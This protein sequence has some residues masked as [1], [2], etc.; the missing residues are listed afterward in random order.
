MEQLNEPDTD[1]G[2]PRHTPPPH[3]HLSDDAAGALAWPV[4][5]PWWALGVVAILSVA[6]VWA[7]LRLR[8]DA[9]LEGLF[10]RDSASGKAV[11]RVLNDFAVAEELLL[12]VSL[13]DGP[14]VSGS[15][16]PAP[17]T[18][19]ALLAFA[20]RLEDSMRTDPD[21][22]GMAADVV[23]RADPQTQQY[24]ERVVA[25]AGLFYLDD[26]AFEQARARLTPEAMREQLKRNE[27][28]VS[29]PGPAAGAMAKVLLQDPLR[30]HEFLTDRFRGARALAPGGAAGA[31]GGPP[32][33]FISPD[34]RSLLIRI[35]GARPPSDMDFTK[36]FTARVAR[37]VDAVNS[38]RLDV[39]Y[40]GA[41]AIAAASERAIRSDAISSSTTSFLYL[42]ALFCL[43]YRSPLRLFALA[44][45]PVV[46]GI[47]VGAG[48][49][50]AWSSS[51]TPMTAV[52]GAMLAE[53][54]IN[55]SV[56]YLSLY[57]SHRGAG[58]A[59]RAAASGS[60]REIAMPLLAAWC[61]SIVGFV[62]VGLSSLRVLRD[63]AVLGT[64]T[65][66]GAVVMTLLLLPA[67]LVLLDR[68]A[69]GPAGAD[70]SAAPLTRFRFGF[71]PAL[72]VMARG[73]RWLALGFG[74]CFL[75]SA[76]VVALPGDRLPLETD[77]TVM[78]PKPNAALDTQT[79][80]SRRFGSSPQS[81]IV[82]LE[83]DSVDALVR[84]AHDVDRR[85]G[86]RAPR[87][88]GVAGTFG[89]ATLLPDPRTVA[90]RAAGFDDPSA[91]RVVASFR[92][93][94]ADS[95]F[96]SAAYEPYAGFLRELLTRR[97]APSIEDLRKYPALTSLV[98]PRTDASGAR[99]SAITL[100][101]LD[102]GLE[103]R[104]TRTRTVEA[105]RAALH[106]LPGATL[107]GLTV[108]S[109]DVESVVA[110]DLPLM[111]GVGSAAVVVYLL[112]HF[113]SVRDTV[114]VVLP[115]AFSIVVLVA[116]MRIGGMKLNMVNLVATP[117]LIGINIDYGIF[118]VS[119]AGA[120]AGRGATRDELMEEI[121]T[122]CHAVLVCALT[123]VLGFGS[124]VFMAIPAVRSLGVAVSI[125]VLSS[126]AA[127]VLFLAPLLL[128]P[129][130][131]AKRRLPNAADA[132]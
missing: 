45:G 56:H 92:A 97:T 130:P 96:Q 40:T 62:A 30:L 24:F 49:Y 75:A 127:T 94:V 34:G 10:P 74:L 124:L 59:P 122:S 33:A 102:R 66:A 19:D 111:L 68:R 79:E 23:Y 128:G 114:L 20:R 119:L 47:L 80:I 8:P 42:G 132:D 11:V 88:Q 35:P 46:F 123:T 65:L 131:L 36:E 57:D 69:L 15:T 99:P 26:R 39:R 125:G 43:A 84:L 58:R 27:A 12:L 41:Y 85:L 126:L 4:R 91:D 61:T 5:R 77:L 82:Y 6:S 48:A 29:V 109:H 72:R 16:R 129:D 2:A 55:Y 95:A 18:S 78:H 110:R 76:V 101:S 1:A 98:L 13:P 81:L 107:T 63:F 104:G 38:D 51:L 87:A 112:A 21:L 71:T 115:T 9:S 70:H 105:I 116:A 121:G 73:G 67:M 53:M 44:F 31:P 86:E 117:L 93:A 83:A 54:G 89:L 52:L 100:V 60:S 103:E 25:P 118:L 113:R 17:A 22:A 108:V 64:L 28:A 90:A 37:A 3:T 7:L 106:G 120:A 50:A 14:A 32:P